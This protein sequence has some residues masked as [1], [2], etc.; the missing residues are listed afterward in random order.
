MRCTLSPLKSACEG[1]PHWLDD[2][3]SIL[4]VLAMLS[5]RHSPGEPWEGISL[6]SS[7]S[8]PGDHSDE[9]IILVFRE[10]IPNHRP[11]NRSCFDI[12]CMQ[13]NLL[14]C[15]TNHNNF[16]SSRTVSW[17]SSLSAF[18]CGQ[19]T[20]S[21]DCPEVI[22]CCV[23]YWRDCRL[24]GNECRRS[25]QW[26]LILSHTLEELRRLLLA[27]WLFP[28]WGTTSSLLF[29]S[30]QNSLAYWFLRSI[31]NHAIRWNLWWSFFARFSKASRRFKRR[32][33]SLY[34]LS[35]CASFVPSNITAVS[36]LFHSEEQPPDTASHTIPDH[37]M[38]MIITW[39]RLGFQLLDAFFQCRAFNVE[40]Y[41]NHILTHS[42][43]FA[44]TWI[45]ETAHSC[46]TCSIPHGWIVPRMVCGST[47][48]HFS[49]L[50]SPFQIFVSSGLFNTVEMEWFSSHSSLSREIVEWCVW[51]RW[52]E[53]L[54]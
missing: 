37:I 9:P 33:I 13:S 25:W 50:I 2:Q 32:N 48:A 20:L 15:K 43:V 40:Y 53:G 7:I 6:R 5:E 47:L 10:S 51:T 28:L 21:S 54:G 16:Q 18:S 4:A 19:R 42:V 12:V 52:T 41:R 39:N 23:S 22:C 45:W 35:Y 44:C 17:N 14:S 24:N 31:G 3:G 30:W 1:M 26:L 36:S 8:R 49:R 46:R 38:T 27:T 11:S 29:T 34:H